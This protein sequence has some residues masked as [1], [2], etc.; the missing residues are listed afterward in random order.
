M[1]LRNKPPH[2]AWVLYV[3][4]GGDMRSKLDVAAPI[5]LVKWSRSTVLSMCYV[6][7]CT[8]G[9]AEIDYSKKKNDSHKKKVETVQPMGIGLFV[10][11]PN[12]GQLSIVRL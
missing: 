7:F 10:R 11:L 5:C 2:G 9:R 6:R 4:A 12:L 8:E 3:S 1:H